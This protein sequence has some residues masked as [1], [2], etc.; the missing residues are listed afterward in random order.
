VPP[1]RRIDVVTLG[2]RT[3]AII[4]KAL[5]DGRLNLLETEA[6]AI[7]EDYGMPVPPFE[8]VHSAEEASDAAAR[9][10]YPVVLKVVSQ[11]ILHKTEAGG[12][13][14][15]IRDSVEARDGFSRIVR[16]AKSYNPNAKLEGVLVQKMAPQGR[17][18]IVGGLI[19]PQFGQTLM[20]GLGGVLV[21]IFKDV[22]L[23]IAPIGEQ[24]A[25]E[26]IREIKAYP[27]LKGYRGQPPVDEDI[28]VEILLKASDLVMENPEINEMDLNPVMI[29]DKGASIVD[30]RMILQR[31]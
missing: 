29:Y 26:M 22:A 20:F 11:D 18:V 28:I 9:L 16:N 14:L 23:R 21:E 3:R 24:E 31:K 17:E 6:K 2:A 13:L 1:H 7:C 8:L 19:D 10:G 15:D 30:A 5:R 27:I 25:S 4:E 12:V